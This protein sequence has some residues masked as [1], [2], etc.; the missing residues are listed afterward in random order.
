MSP[1]HRPESGDDGGGPASPAT[2][3][4]ASLVLLDR[5]T[6]KKLGGGPLTPDMFA[7]PNAKSLAAAL[8]L[9]YSRVNGKSR[10]LRVSLWALMVVL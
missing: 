1:T 9:L 6:W 7:R 3:L 5:G 4:Y 2:L 8:Y 10:A